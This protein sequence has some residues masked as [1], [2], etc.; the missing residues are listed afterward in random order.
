M[1]FDYHVARQDTAFDAR[2]R[3]VKNGESVAEDATFDELP[4]DKIKELFAKAAQSDQQK[5]D[6]AMSR[7]EMDVWIKTHPEYRD[8]AANA[9]QLL[10]QVRTMFSTVTPSLQQAEAAYDALR[11]TDLLDI[12]QAELAR[13]KDRSDAQRAKEIQDAGGVYVHGHPSEQEMY[14][15]P[16]EDLRRLGNNTKPDGRGRL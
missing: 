1:S 7:G 9:K 12:N 15:M 14:E 16:L 5:A 6:A 3:K 2:L 8:H 10:N 11:D 4:A 13:Q